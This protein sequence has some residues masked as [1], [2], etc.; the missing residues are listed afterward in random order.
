[1]FEVPSVTGPSSKLA[2]NRLTTLL[3]AHG[4]MARIQWLIKPRPSLAP[5]FRSRASV[6]PHA[7]PPVSLRRANPLEHRSEESKHQFFGT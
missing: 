7:R 2:K 6:Q 1:M 3:G 4:L 5:R